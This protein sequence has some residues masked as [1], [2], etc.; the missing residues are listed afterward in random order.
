DVR[1]GREEGLEERTV[2]IETARA[3]DLGLTRAEI[4]ATLETYVLGRVATH[5]REEGDEYDVRVMLR[6]EDRART[7]QLGSLPIL[8]PRGVVP[9]AAVAQIGARR[10]PASIEREGQ[11]RV[12]SIVGGLGDRPLSAVVADLEDAL[13]TIERPTGFSIAIAGEAREQ[14]ATFRG[15]G[16]GIVLAVLLVF[17]VM[18]VQ[19]ES[20]R[21]P[22]L[23]MSAVPFGFVGVIATLVATGTTFS[24]NAFLGC[25]VLVGIAVNNA[26]VLID[27]ANLLRRERELD[28]ASAM[29]QAGRQRLRPILM[30]TST[31]ALGV[32]PIALAIG[33]GAEIQAPLAR[34][35]LGGLVVSAIITLVLL[36]ALY[37]LAERR[38][39]AGRRGP[40]NLAGG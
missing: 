24:L 10:G 8:S 9:L 23:V 13:A 15:L 27:T 22:L 32:L 17:A 16:V 28:A 4:A 25:I 2:L 26:I 21:D 3:A 7:D 39:G 19:F 31:T 18:A 6:E 14:E 11:E 37:V 12:V 40:A 36:P 5:L 20:L 30:T 33:E 35:V 34:V 29:L 38:S 1:I